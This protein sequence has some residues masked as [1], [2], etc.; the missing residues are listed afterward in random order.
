MVKRWMVSSKSA[1]YSFT[2]RKSS[3]LRPL[4]LI[5]GFLKRPLKYYS[6]EP[7]IANT[8]SELDNLR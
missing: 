2:D 5:L 7:E 1:I 3:D 4:S 8:S 6:I